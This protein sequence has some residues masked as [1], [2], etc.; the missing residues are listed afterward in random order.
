L[1]GLQGFHP[2]LNDILAV[3]Q[4]ALSHPNAIKPDSARR[5]GRTL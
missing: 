5:V 1:C 4:M 2:E 3:K